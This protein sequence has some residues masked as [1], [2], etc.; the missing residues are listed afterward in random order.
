MKIAVVG[1]HV[2][3]LEET[4]TA[5]FILDA[6]FCR[7]SNG[8]NVLVSGGAEGIDTMAE[9]L[10]VVWGWCQPSIIHEPENPQWEPRGY[11]ARNLLIAKDC[12]ILICIKA[13]SSITHGSIFTA[14][15]AEKWGKPV[16]RIYIG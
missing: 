1:S 9:N 4:E 6:I 3:T 8:Q 14:R 16:R 10:T 11:K 15:E 5:A 7:Y 12:D 13:K 2:L